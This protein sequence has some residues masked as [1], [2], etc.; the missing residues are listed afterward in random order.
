L[1]LLQTVGE[2]LRI[3]STARDRYA[4]GLLLVALICLV[5]QFQDRVQNRFSVVSIVF[6]AIMATYG[7]AITHNIFA[8]Y[9]AR[10][11]MAAELRAAHIFQT[12]VCWANFRESRSL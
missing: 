3:P 9:R 5:R 8:L 6:I 1:Q 10:V 4:L 12:V 11:A 7:V 2:Y